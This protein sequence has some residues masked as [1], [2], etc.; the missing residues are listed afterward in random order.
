MNNLGFKIRNCLTGLISV[1]IFLSTCCGINQ[2][3]P[4]DNTGFCGLLITISFILY[5]IYVFTKELESAIKNS[6]DI[7][8]CIYSLDYSK[9]TNI[10]KIE[11]VYNESHYQYQ[12][13]LKKC[14]L[15]FNLLEC[16]IPKN[17][18]ELQLLDMQ[19]ENLAVDKK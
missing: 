7:A 17:Q 3:L 10:D 19:F 8:K 11:I 18:N 1:F 5:V 12:V 2:V 13:Y 4:F 6:L 14:N 9:L 16:K 15:H